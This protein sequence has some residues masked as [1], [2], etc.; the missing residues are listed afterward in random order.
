MISGRSQ[1][2]PPLVPEEPGW[3]RTAKG[4]RSVRDILP[5]PAAAESYAPR[6]LVVQDSQSTNDPGSSFIRELQ[7]EGYRV[8]IAATSSDCIRRFGNP[9]DVVVIASLNRR[10]RWTELFRRIREIASTPIVIGAPPESEIEAVLAFELGATAYVSDAS[11]TREL[12][13]RVRSALHLTGSSLGSSEKPVSVMTTSAFNMGRLEID[14][15]GREV[16]ASGTTVY[17]ARR[18]FELLSVLLS[19]PGVVRTRRELGDQ[20]WNGRWQEGS[21]T[22]DTH[23]RRLRLKLES[24]PARPRRLITVRGVGFRFDITEDASRPDNLNVTTRS[25]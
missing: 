13:A 2:D 4:P 8:E 22:L 15:A 12:V 23:I 24:N 11:R 21:R 3:G 1:M 7:N 25:T 20:V 18:E 6:V 9:P 16:K 5:A 17:L 19:P 14:L 10:T